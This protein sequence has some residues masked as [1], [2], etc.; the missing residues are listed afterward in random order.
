MEGMPNRRQ[1]RLMAKEAGFL[2][3][4]RKASYTERLEMSRRALEFGKK[5]HFYNTEQVLRD[6]EASKQLAEQKKLENLVSE[7]KTEEEA[8]QILQKEK[9]SEE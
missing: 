7:G 3:K 1:R 6:E 2:E 4:K 9:E 5:I 8:L